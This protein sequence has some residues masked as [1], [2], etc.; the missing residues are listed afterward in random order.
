MRM[1]KMKSI[2]IT[3]KAQTNNISCG[4]LFSLVSNTILALD[5]IYIQFAI[6]QYFS[7]RQHIILVYFS[8]LI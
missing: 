4:T 2:I 5:D 8:I 3:K 1:Q 6:Q 7:F